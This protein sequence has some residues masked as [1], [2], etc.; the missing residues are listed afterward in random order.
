MISVNDRLGLL[1]WFTIAGAPGRDED[2]RRVAGAVAVSNEDLTNWF[3]DLGLDPH[4]LPPQIAAINA[5]RT[6]SSRIAASYDLPV[7]GQRAKLVVEEVVSDPNQVRRYILREVTDS[8]HRKVWRDRAAEL[9][10]FKARRTS[11]GKIPGTERLRVIYRADLPAL[12]RRIVEEQVEL[13]QQRYELASNMRGDTDV[14]SMVRAYVRGLGA[15]MLAEKGL[16]FIAA[17]HEQTIRAL[18]QLLDRLGP[19]SSLHLCPLVDTPEQRDMIGAAMNRQTEDDAWALMTAIR[20][21]SNGATGALSTTKVEEF[22][23]TL[24]ALTGRHAARLSWLGLSTERGDVALR[25]A[26]ELITTRGPVPSGS[27]VKV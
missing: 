14:R 5:F 16:Y 7:T 20:R 22:T 23:R 9:R 15:I 27:G 6:S 3:T 24:G 4:Y 18:G 17:Q 19:G 13:F 10:Y 26:Q 11:A 12:D 2:G 21:H 1:F 8:R 25:L